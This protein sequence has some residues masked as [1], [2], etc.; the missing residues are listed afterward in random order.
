MA[1]VDERNLRAW[2]TTAIEPGDET[3]LSL[4][5]RYGAEHAISH[6]RS[7]SHAAVSRLHDLS[8]RHIEKLLHESEF[9]FVLP[10]DAEWPQGLALLGPS[11]PIGLWVR[12][13]VSSLALAAVSIVG[14][15]SCTQYGSYVATEFGASIAQAGWCVVSG[16]ATGIDGAAHRGALALQA[17]TIAIMAGGLSQLYPRTHA[18]LFRRIEAQGA[19]V[20]EAGPDVVPLKHRFL[21]RNRLIAS[22]SRV[23]VVV[24]ARQRSGAIATASQAAALGRDVAVVPGLITSPSSRGCHHLIRDGAVLV[25]EASEVFELAGG[26]LPRHTPLMGD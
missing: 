15:R 14:S 18:E 19:L 3:I 7:Q 25:T 4:V 2:L 11:E 8:L 5:H 1:S 24:E 6:L 23:T 13:D 10:T 9:H 20:S 16:G 12:G 22:W 21:V 17:P 26:D